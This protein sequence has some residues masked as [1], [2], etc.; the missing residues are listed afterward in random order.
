[1]TVTCPC[2]G[3]PM[4]DGVAVKALTAIRLGYVQATVLR[5]LVDAFPGHAQSDR[6]IHAAYG[7]TDD[8]A[9]MD[10]RRA[11]REAVKDLRKALPAHGWRVSASR[12]GPV[13]GAWRLER[14]P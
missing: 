13:P 14:M 1:M 9:P 7:G 3:A 4:A 10:A 8:D 6:I 12:R 11:I 5:A 2:C